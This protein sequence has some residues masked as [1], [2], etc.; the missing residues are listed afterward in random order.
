MRFVSPV[1][2]LARA[3]TRDVEVS[4]VTIPA[5]DQVLLLYGS[6]NHDD[7]VFSDPEVLDFDRDMKPHWVFGHGIHFCLGNAVARLETRVA[8][9]VLVE[10]LGDWDLEESE[11]V[12]NQLVPTRGIA[13]AP[14]RFE[15]RRI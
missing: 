4:G 14:V 1:Q 13:Q 10:T 8:L 3:T 15:T 5:G 2:G 6:A 7:T 9:Q 11:I 12:R